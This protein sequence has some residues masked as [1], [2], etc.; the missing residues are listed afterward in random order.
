MR[1]EDFRELPAPYV[2]R[3][4]DGRSYTNTHPTNAF[5]SEVYPSTVVVFAWGKRIT[6][7]GNRPIVS[8]RHE[9]EV[10]APG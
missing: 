10:V 1:P 7:L 5:I 2:I 4:K 3:T 6:F 8:I 9:H